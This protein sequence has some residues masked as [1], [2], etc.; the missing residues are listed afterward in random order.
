MKVVMINGSSRKNGTTALALAEVAKPIQEA[1]IETE[2]LHVGGKPIA[3]CIGCGQCGR[4][5]KC[6]V[7]PNDFVN[8]WLD[9]IRAADGLVI[10]SPV[11]FSSPS[12]RLIAALDRMFYAGGDAFEHKPM[13]SVVVARRAG[14][15]A[16]L[17]VLNKYLTY[18]QTPLVS[19][20]YWNMVHGPGP[21]QITQDQEG[22]QTM[23]NL[24]RNMVWMLRCIEA[25]REKGIEPPAAESGART[26]FNR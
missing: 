11:Y 14:T 21:E 12:G 24:G 9:K 23:R 2:I 6:V 19:S 22:L 10:G 18:Y 17:D 20:T 26:N 13:A 15:T 1:G 16:A 4:K 8:E 25:G 7:F 5:G 3:G